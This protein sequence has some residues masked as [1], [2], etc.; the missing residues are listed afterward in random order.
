MGQTPEQARTSYWLI[1]TA[2]S[3]YAVS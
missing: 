1:V 2:T 3:R